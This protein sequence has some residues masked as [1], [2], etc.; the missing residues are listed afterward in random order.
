[1]SRTGA[2]TPLK[3]KRLNSRRDAAPGPTAGRAGSH[4][5]GGRAR[6]AHTGRRWPVKQEPKGVQE[7]AGRSAPPP[8]GPADWRD[9][10]TA[11]AAPA[12][13][14]SRAAVRRGRRK[15]GWVG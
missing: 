7:R 11:L 5:G 4:A 8:P 1:M 2:M 3:R 9:R 14:L 10:A 13:I 15:L 12:G 6:P